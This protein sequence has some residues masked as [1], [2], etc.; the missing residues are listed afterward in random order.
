MDNEFISRLVNNYISRL[1]AN[2]INIKEVY[3]FGSIAKN[4]GQ[5]YSDVD[6]AII[7]DKFK[8]RFNFEIQLMSLRNDD[9][10]IIEPH[11]FLKDEFNETDPFVHEIVK[12]G[13]KIIF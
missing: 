9:E 5:E 13:K 4:T 2:K 3:L 1:V 8:N 10:T 11:V 6:L 12:T 7:V